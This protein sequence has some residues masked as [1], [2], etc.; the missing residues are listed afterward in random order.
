MTAPRNLPIKRPPVRRKERIQQW[1]SN[2]L[3]QKLRASAA[4]QNVTE[5]SLTEAALTEYLD[6]ERVDRAWL[7]RRLDILSQAVGQAHAGLERANAR[8]ERD[9]GFL[10]DS[11]GVFV[12]YVF[13][14]ATTKPGAEQEQIME[15]TYQK[16]L[17]LVRDPN[18]QSGRLRQEPRGPDTSNAV[19]PASTANSGGR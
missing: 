8:A 7:A 3:R 19:S 17:R 12:R 9:M 15:A 4:A 16:F 11:F 1:V 2:G 18:R 6:P 5:S 14:H 10:C 13:L